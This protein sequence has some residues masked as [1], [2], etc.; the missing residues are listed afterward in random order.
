MVINN[1]YNKD[2]N[3][4]IENYLNKFGVKDIN[5]F[6]NPTDKYVES[7]FFYHNME[8]AAQ[9]FKWFHLDPDS[10]VYIL[11]DSGD[12]DGITSACMIYSYMKRLREDWDIKILIHDGKERGLQDEKLFNQVLNEPRDLIIIPDSGTNDKEQVNIIYDKTKSEIIVL[13]HHDFSTPIEKGILVNNQDKE[14]KCQRN[15]SGCLVAHKFLQMLDKV[16][17]VNYSDYYIDLVALS[18]VSDS[19]DMTELENR[20]YYHYGLETKDRIVNKFLYNCIETF[21]KKD[22]YTQKD[23]AFSVIPKFNSISRSTD[24]ELKQK[25]YLAFLEEYDDYTEILKLCANSHTNQKNIVDEI[26]NNNIKKIEEISKNNLVIFVSDDIPKSYSGLV[27]GKIMNLSGGKP[28]L[29]GSIKDGE[30]IGSLR[31]PIPLREELNNNELVEWCVGHEEASGI[32]IKEENLEAIVNY[33]NFLK[34]DYS[35]HIT[36]LNSYTVKSLPKYLFGLF[37]PY[38]ALFGKGIP[39]PKFFVDKINFSPEDVEILGRDKRTL[40]ITV[41]DISIMIFNCTRKNKTDLMLGYYDEKNKFIEDR[42]K[43]QLEMSCICTL[44]I[45]EWNDKKTKQIIVEDFEIKE[46]PKMRMED[47]I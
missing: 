5:E 17:N 34:L 38:N 31:S 14:S 18:L 26:I 12:T 27:C 32:K 46:K 20:V 43:V 9:C 37:E 33:Y 11:S 45:N 3:I 40:K 21:I 41:D 42:K 25:L 47:L 23:L 7:P 8:E 35:P 28:T 2:E 16:L 6:L 24:M 29:A 13:D 44:N 39:E 22:S 19:M 10:T 4:S 15:G 1:L 36:V 30:F